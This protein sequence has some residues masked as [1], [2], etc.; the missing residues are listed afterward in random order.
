MYVLDNLV[1]G[2][3]PGLHC[4]FTHE[5]SGEKYWFFL[6]WDGGKYGG[7]EALRYLEEGARVLLAVEL[8]VR[9]RPKIVSFE[10]VGR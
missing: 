3:K 4:Y 7:C 9:G 5:A 8:T 6:H 2:K 10:V 1:W